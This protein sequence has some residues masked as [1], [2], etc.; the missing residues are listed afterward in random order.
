MEYAQFSWRYM[1]INEMNF[2]PQKKSFMFKENKI[3]SYWMKYDKSCC[4]V[5]HSQVRRGG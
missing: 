2:Y 5:C 4:S 1:Q 3:S